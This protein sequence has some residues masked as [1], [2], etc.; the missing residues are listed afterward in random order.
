MVLKIVKPQNM[1]LTMKVVHEISSWAIADVSELNMTE[2]R[3]IYSGVDKVNRPVQFLF[4]GL[5]ELG[6]C[7]YR[8]AIQQVPDNDFSRVLR[9]SRKRW[10][11][12]LKL[13][14]KKHPSR[15]FP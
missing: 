6:N 15:R 13:K 8:Q 1:G 5:A 12:Y 3:N 7:C 4:I 10:R 14:Y 2:T 11:L 9:Q